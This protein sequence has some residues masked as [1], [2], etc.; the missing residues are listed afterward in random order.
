[1]VRQ[2][3]DV[4]IERTQLL[5]V[6]KLIVKYNPIIVAVS[7]VLTQ[8]LPQ[9]HDMTKTYDQGDFYGHSGLTYG[10]VTN[11]SDE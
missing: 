9:M 10:C 7:T 11:F 5:F 1:M 4:M 3:R 2:V 8:K 6:C